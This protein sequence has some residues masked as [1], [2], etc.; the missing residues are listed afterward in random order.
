MVFKN[1][2]CKFNEDAVGIQ[3]I[4]ILKDVLDTLLSYNSKLEEE[5]RELMGKS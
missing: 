3:H 5:G 2:N 1:E 4:N